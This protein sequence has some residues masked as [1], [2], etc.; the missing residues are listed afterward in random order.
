[1]DWMLT[2]NGY[3]SSLAATLGNKFF[4][5]NGYLGIRGTLEEYEKDQLV[6]INLSGIYDQV[7]KKFREPINAPNALYTYIEIAGERIGLPNSETKSHQITLDFAH[8]LFGRKTS[9]PTKDGEITVESERFCCMEQPHIICMKYCIHTGVDMEV[10]L[11]SGIDADV[12]DINGPHLNN[13]KF[14]SSSKEENTFELSVHANT[15]EKRIGINV[16]EITSLRILDDII[17][18]CLEQRKKQQYTHEVVKAESK[19]LNRFTISLP[20]NGMVCFYKYIGIYT[21]KDSALYERENKEL[22]HH[23]LLQGYGTLKSDHMEWWKKCWERDQVVLEGDEEAMQ[24]LNYSLYHLICIAPRHSKSMSIPARGLS[25]QTYKGAVFWDTEMFLLPFYLYTEPK[26]ARSLVKYRI[27]T[28]VGAKKKAKEYGYLGAFYAWESQEGGYEACSDYNVIDVFTERPMRTYFRDKQIHISSAVV[29]GLMSYVHTTND[30]SVLEEGGVEVVLECAQFYYS[31][32]LQKVPFGQFEL[33]DVVGPDEYHERVNNNF[34]TNRMA[35]FTFDMA[36]EL[37]QNI[38]KLSKETQNKLAKQYGLSALLTKFE[39]AS[40]RIY[41][42][43]PDKYTKLIEQFDGYYKLKDSTL[44]EVRSKVIHP[45]EYWGGAYGVA[46][47][48][49]I[50]KQ[51]DVVTTLALFR[52]EYEQDALQKNW[53]YYEPRTEHGSSLSAC[54]YA[55]LACY[56][57][58]PDQAY[59]FFLKSAMADLKGGGKEWAGLLYIGGTHPAAAGGAYM[60]AVYGF[61]GLTIKEGSIAV[62]PC[63]PSSITKLSF[64]VQIGEKKYRVTVTK[65]EAFAVCI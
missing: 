48:T 36:V 43:D 22:L 59:P 51:A 27:D 60:T 17:P 65:E 57:G 55:L 1:M 64:L 14:S 30:Y 47:D 39:E 23:A 25:G 6:A 42:K 29:Y 56:C 4:I 9:Y 62:K 32:L 13:V 40:K 8:G 52:E 50:I 58:N 44:D 35:K 28:L 16:W 45:K 3:D 37:I 49:K 46:A 21:E 2:E 12:W 41:L 19:I 53:D 33:H 5:G 61:A 38:S 63:L 20:A 15:S 7:E 34:Y 11:V 24:A 26:V 10:T 18:D 54:M 31:M